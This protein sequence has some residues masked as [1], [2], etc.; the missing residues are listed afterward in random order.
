MR[1]EGDVDGQRWTATAENPQFSAL[2]DHNHQGV[3]RRGGRGEGGWVGGLVG[4]WVG[5]GDVVVVMWCDVVWCGVVWCG[6]VRCV[7]ACVCVC[8]GGGG[9][10]GADVVLAVCLCRYTIAGVRLIGVAEGC[11]VVRCG[12]VWWWWCGQDV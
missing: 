6:A 7:R 11:G 8:G 3:G 10:G 2:S 12:V 9:G 5:G 4:W 1:H